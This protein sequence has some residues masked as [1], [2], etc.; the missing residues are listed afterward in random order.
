MWQLNI[1]LTLSV[2][3]LP[4]PKKMADTIQGGVYLSQIMERS[5]PQELSSKDQSTGPHTNEKKNFIAL[6]TEI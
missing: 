4:S 2:F 5:C 1:P 6:T 3:P